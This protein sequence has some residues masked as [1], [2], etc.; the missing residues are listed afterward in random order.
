M[1]QSLAECSVKGCIQDLCAWKWA[2]TL[3]MEWTR[4]WSSSLNVIFVFLLNHSGETIIHCRKVL[5]PVSELGVRSQ[6]WA[7]AGNIS[8]ECHRGQISIHTA[9]KPE[10]TNILLFWFAEVWLQVASIFWLTREELLYARS[11]LRWRYP[12]SRKPKVCTAISFG[13]QL[14]TLVVSEFLGLVRETWKKKTT[15]LLELWAGRNSEE[16]VGVL[17]EMSEAKVGSE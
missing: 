16:T 11:L 13:F 7:L 15:V 12:S 17:I 3:T 4:S 10:T 2:V 14:H 6:L 5:V 1:F 9:K 8:R